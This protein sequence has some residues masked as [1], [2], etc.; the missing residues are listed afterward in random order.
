MWFFRA[1][2]LNLDETVTEG[3][4]AT[5]PPNSHESPDRPLHGSGTVEL[6]RLAD[7]AGFDKTRLAGNPSRGVNREQAVSGRAVCSMSPRGLVSRGGGSRRG[8]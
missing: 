2:A 1:V 8:R 4:S 5:P 6:R 7:R 3:E